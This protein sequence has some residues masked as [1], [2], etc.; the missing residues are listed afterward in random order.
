[1]T[2]Q[3]NARRERK[4]L[5]PGKMTL[6]R[7][8]VQVFMLVL[9][10]LPVVA[11]GW[12]LFGTTAPTGEQMATPA[13]LP[14][15][16]TLSSSSIGPVTV[17][18][19]FATLQVICASKAFDPAWLVGVLPVLIVYGLIRGRAFCGWVCPVNLLGEAVDF[20]R[21]KLRRPVYEMPVPRH[22][23]LYVA[24]AVLVLSLLLGI[25][26]YEIFNPIGAINKLV[27]LGAVTGVVTLVC[28]VA[29]ELFWGHR[30]WCR[31]LCPLGGF[32]EALGRVGLLSVRIDHDACIGCGKCQKACLCD[33][34]ILDD[35]IS[36]TANAVT[37]GDC[38]L[39]GKCLDAC[40]TSALKVG[41]GR[42]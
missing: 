37:A 33:P 13:E 27:A 6:A 21:R 11:A 8:C 23:K 32:Y 42:K 26:V 30:V 31:A 39:C 4:V 15:F 3:A 10:A 16:G 41:V 25:P 36:G 20:L 35:A 2:N 29:V 12:G 19:P 17:L 22:A 7:R 18:D 24:G 5:G 14:F 34:A 38:M 1:M 9:F 40:P 28:I